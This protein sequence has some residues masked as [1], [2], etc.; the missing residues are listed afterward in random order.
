MAMLAVCVRANNN[1]GITQF[2]LKQDPPDEGDDVWQIV[3]VKSVESVPGFL[4]ERYGTTLSK[5]SDYDRGTPGDWRIKT[6]STTLV[7]KGFCL[8]AKIQKGI[9]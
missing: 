5:V 1:I 8:F 7:W 2:V 4:K 6:G 3:D 9:T